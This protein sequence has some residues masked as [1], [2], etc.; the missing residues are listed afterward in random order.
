MEYNFVKKLFAYKTTV[1]I[2]KRMLNEGV[3]TKEEYNLIDTII[4]KK[5]GFDLCS[6]YR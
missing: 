5:Y 3:I 2:M 4:A 6:I 1:V